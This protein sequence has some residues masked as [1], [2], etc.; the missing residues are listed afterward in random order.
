[1]IKSKLSWTITALLLSLMVLP[2][3]AADD[4]PIVAEIDGEL[5]WR[6]SDV[7]ARIAE[8]PAQYQQSMQLPEQRTEFLNQLV[9][10][11]QLALQSIDDG[12]EETAEYQ[13]KLELYRLNT[14]AM[15]AWENRMG[16][17][18]GVSEVELQEY[19]DDHPEKFMTNAQARSRHMLFLTR[20]D[21]TAARAQLEAGGI[22]FT[23]LAKEVSLDPF[24]NRL[25]G[26]LGLVEKD[27]PIPQLGYMPELNTALFELPV[28]MISEPIET[29]MGW[30]I[31]LVE[32]RLEPALKAYDQIRGQLIKRVL[33][34]EDVVLSTWEEKQENYIDLPEV[35]LR[36]IICADEEAIN[37]AFDL[38]ST[39]KE[40]AEVAAEMSDDEASAENGGLLGFLST[41]SQ[42]R[43]LGGSAKPVI[44]FALTDLND[45][46]FS[47]PFETPDGPWVIVQRDA[48]RPQRKL[49]FE[50]VELDVLGNLL[51][52]YSQV[53]Y[54]DFYAELD[55]A[56][57]TS[58]NYEALNAT[59]KPDETAAELYEL[60]EVAPPPT[61][62]NYYEK[63]LE[64]YP[65]SP[66]AAKAQF[67][68]GFLY[69]DKLKNFDAA[70]TAF[71]AYL[72]NWSSGELAESASYM[73]EHMRDE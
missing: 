40:F 8:L 63:I 3:L 58:F 38:L 54:D 73:L 34:P 18:Y 19:Y 65:D 13:R 1:M 68:I 71:N 31:A 52:R 60:A 67:M 12:M 30:H 37:D 9:R 35:Y 16:T 2:S 69:S 24:T 57:P 47:D 33:I 20:A 59:P 10:E 64:F 61:A 14:L 55:S 72:E 66:E 7:E 41:N 62:I 21:A 36:L 49:T 51:S 43:A 39:G 48:Y 6:V 70:E 22:T 4:D 45:G 5:I 25:G 26:M 42:V 27:R 29:D 53:R 28:G 56:Y 11:Y 15:M 32:E 44:E 46:E 23:E 17:T 50:E